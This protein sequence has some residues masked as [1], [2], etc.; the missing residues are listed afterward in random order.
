M[1]QLARILPATDLHTL[2]A[3]AL[4]A[5]R[6][7]NTCT[8]AEYG[9]TIAAAFDA[10]ENFLAALR[11]QTGI[12]DAMWRELGESILPVGAPSENPA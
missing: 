7:E 9:D 12:D 1:N 5:H 8:D 2:A 10:R 6:A 4:A 3:T 11:E